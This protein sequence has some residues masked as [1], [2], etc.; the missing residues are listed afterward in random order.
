MDVTEA[1]TERVD[2]IG[3]LVGADTTVTVAVLEAPGTLSGKGG[4]R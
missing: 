2:I 4:S 3:D 1:V